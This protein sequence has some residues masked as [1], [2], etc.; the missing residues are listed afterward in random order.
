VAGRAPRVFGGPSQR[1]AELADRFPA[2]PEP[3]HLAKLLGHVTIVQ[4]GIDGAPQV[5][6][7]IP[8]RRGQSPVRGA[9]A[10]PV[11]QA[12][13]PRG[14]EPALEPLHLPDAEP[15]GRGHLAIRELSRDQGFDQPRPHHFL[16]RHREGLPCL[17][18]GDTFTQQS[19]DDIFM[20]E[21][22]R[23][24]A[25]LTDL[26]LPRSVRPDGFLAPSLPAIRRRRMP[27]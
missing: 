22:Q 17:H 6:H 20:R 24:T 25:A 26:A 8:K 10:G 14:L 19:G 1:L 2:H 13:R 11:H 27:P 4:A 7:A 15:E 12:R 21:Q 18:G 3:L 23:L 16:A 5:H 9:P